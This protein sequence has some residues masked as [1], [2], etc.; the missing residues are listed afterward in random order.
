MK[1]Y[2]QME[3]TDLEFHIGV[4]EKNGEIDELTHAREIC[5]KKRFEL[6]KNYDTDYERTKYKTL[7]SRILA[8]IVDWIL[9]ALLYYLI[10]KL[11]LISESGGYWTIFW[12]VTPYLYS[13]LFHAKFGQTLGKMYV[14]VRVVKE[15]DE[16]KI[17][18]MQ[19]M[20]RDAVPLVLICM[21]LMPLMGA[22]VVVK[23]FAGILLFIWPLLEIFTALFNSKRRALHD[24]IARTVVIHDKQA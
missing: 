1:N 8:A 20:L 17:E 6:Q 19:A 13:I 2:E 16:G 9:L 5:D 21:S 4:L 14:G 15:S 11:R 23:V 22:Y 10:S 12:L 7:G 18:I 3:I 24:F